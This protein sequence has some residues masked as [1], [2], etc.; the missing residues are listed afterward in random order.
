M[1]TSSGDNSVERVFSYISEIKVVIEYFKVSCYKNIYYL[2]FN[3]LTLHLKIKMLTKLN[4]WAAN[5]FLY[6]TC[7]THVHD[8]AAAITESYVAAK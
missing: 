6:E 2:N 5:I 4:T 3:I 7:S 8:L 1:S